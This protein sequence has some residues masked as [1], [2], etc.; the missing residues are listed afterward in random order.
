MAAILASIGTAGVPGVGLG[1]RAVTCIVAKS[2]GALDTAIFNSP[3]AGLKEEEID[4][5]HIR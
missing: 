2:E 1:D 3:E 4:F 5:H